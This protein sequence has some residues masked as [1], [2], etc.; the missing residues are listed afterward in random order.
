M[1]PSDCELSEYGDFAD[2]IGV[3]KRKA[4][5]QVTERLTTGYCSGR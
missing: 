5:Q 2:A 3:L 4:K 1:R